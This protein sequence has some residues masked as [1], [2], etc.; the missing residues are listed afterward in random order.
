MY[1]SEV[2]KIFNVTKAEAEEWGKILKDDVLITLYYP[3]VG[4]VE[5]RCKKVVKEEE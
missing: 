4:D 5:L 2:A 3:T 1:V